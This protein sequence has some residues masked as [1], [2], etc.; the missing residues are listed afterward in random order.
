MHQAQHTGGRSGFR[1]QLVVDDEGF[2]FELF[3]PWAPFLCAARRVWNFLSG[4]FPGLLICFWVLLHT[5]P[6]AL[7][8]WGCGA[9]PSS[10]WLPVFVPLACALKNLAVTVLAGFLGPQNPWVQ[11]AWD[12]AWR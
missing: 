1:H 5:L 12:V 2:S 8:A 7:T 11:W 10:W 3:V 6:R 9:L 4:T